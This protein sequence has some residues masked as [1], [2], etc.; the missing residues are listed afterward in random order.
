[1]VVGQHDLHRGEVGATVGF[2][3]FHV[4]LVW[5]G[6]MQ[7]GLSTVGPRKGVRSEF[8][9]AVNG[10]LVHEQVLTFFG[11]APVLNRIARGVSAVEVDGDLLTQRPGGVIDHQG[12]DPGQ[13][14]LRTGHQ[15]GHGME[16]IGIGPTVEVGVV[17]P[18][19]PDHGVHGT[20]QNGLVGD[21]DLHH[22]RGARRPVVVPVHRGL[23]DTRLN[24]VDR[25]G[26]AEGG[27]F[28]HA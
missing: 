22:L 17:D 15:H 11:A 10:Q 14:G 1:M 5:L 4:Q 25:E 27:G 23:H 19:F 9:R 26:P 2:A 8:G 28:N 24:R 7:P 21:G 12:V 3:D 6:G 18:L 16:F 20:G 13:G